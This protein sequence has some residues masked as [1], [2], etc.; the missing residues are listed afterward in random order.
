MIFFSIVVCLIVLGKYYTRRI[1]TT[2]KIIQFIFPILYLAVSE[3]ILYDTARAGG[4]GVGFVLRGMSLSYIPFRLLMILTPP[5]SVFEILTAS[6]SF[7][8]FLLILTE[9]IVW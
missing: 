9:V 4:I 3:V 1:T 8:W 6:I 5:R 7:T 2:E